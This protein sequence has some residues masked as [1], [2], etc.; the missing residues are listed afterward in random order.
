[1]YYPNYSPDD[2]S[3]SLDEKL[4]LLQQLS[5]NPAHWLDEDP[6]DASESDATASS[7]TLPLDGAHIA[8]PIIS[9]SEPLTRPP[10]PEEVN[11]DAC[12]ACVY[13]PTLFPPSSPS[14]GSLSVGILP[15]VCDREKVSPHCPCTALSSLLLSCHPRKIFGLPG[16]TDADIDRARQRCQH[17]LGVSRAGAH[18]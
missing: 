18:L 3:R 15:L 6:Y 17:Q 9:P 13:D 12:E 11:A 1:M 2:L 5:D 16:A 8:V 7:F 4:E 14:R 10:P